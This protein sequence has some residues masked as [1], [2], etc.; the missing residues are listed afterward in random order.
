MPRD[1]FEP[2]ISDLSDLRPSIERS[3]LLRP[4]WDLNP[5]NLLRDKQAS[6]PDWTAGAYYLQ[7]ILDDP[8]FISLISV[9]KLSLLASEQ[10]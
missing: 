10:I 6:T 2:I 9:S 4:R 8:R 5:R 1:G 3:G 7:D